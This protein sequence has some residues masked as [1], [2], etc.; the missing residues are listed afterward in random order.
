MSICCSGVIV[1]WCYLAGSGSGWGP[2]SSRRLR[3]CDTTT[4][5]SPIVLGSLIGLSTGALDLVTPN[6]N[7]G[8][9]CLFLRNYVPGESN[10]NINVLTKTLILEIRHIFC[11]FL[12]IT[13]NT[14][15]NK[16]IISRFQQGL[17]NMSLFMNTYYLL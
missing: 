13:F 1:L 15:Y 17:T 12:S 2:D 9:Y 8:V 6:V 16:K 10:V 4:L 11:L 14:F 5:G 3:S 7:D